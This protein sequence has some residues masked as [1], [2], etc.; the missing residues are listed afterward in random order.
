MGFLHKLWDE[1]VAGPTPDNGLGKLRK[2]DSLSTVRSSPP[3]LSSDQ[4]T[5]SIMVTKG[6]NNVRGLRKLKMDPDSPTCS[7]SNP[8]TPLTPGTPCYALGPFTAGKIPSSGE[9]DAASLTTYEWLSSLS[10]H[11]LINSLF[12]CCGQTLYDCDKRV[13]PL[14]KPREKNLTGFLCKYK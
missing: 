3:S 14:N 8:G 2:H 1:T 5:R 7:S 13:G 10:L 9:D 11:F 4:V 6:N 12:C